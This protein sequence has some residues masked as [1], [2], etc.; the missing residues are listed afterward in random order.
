MWLME[1]SEEQHHGV[2]FRLAG[3]TKW[4]CVPYHE[5]QHGDGPLGRTDELDNGQNSGNTTINNNDKK[6]I[7]GCFTRMEM[8]WIISFLKL[9]DTRKET[10]H[11]R[12]Y[13]RSRPGGLRSLLW[14]WS[15]INTIVL[16][17]NLT[18]CDHLW[19]GLGDLGKPDGQHFH[20]VTVL[21]WWIDFNRLILQDKDSFLNGNQ[22]QILDNDWR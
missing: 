4:T 10:C 15:S 11:M 16:R 13:H 22:I 17:A 3:W 7:L 19:I 1:D 21:G 20:K 14:R 8:A 2:C 5:S 6:T 9:N 12:Y 18:V